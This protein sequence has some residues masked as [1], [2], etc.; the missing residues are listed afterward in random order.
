MRGQ[1]RDRE[2][3]QGHGTEDTAHANELFEAFE[4]LWRVDELFDKA[5]DELALY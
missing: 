2:S 1:K 3:L 5:Y 4:M